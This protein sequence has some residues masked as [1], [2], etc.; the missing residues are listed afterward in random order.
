[1]ELPQLALRD[2]I[3]LGV[4]RALG[5]LTGLVWAPL[6][7]GVMYFVY[8]WRID[9]VAALRREYQ[10]LRKDGGPLVICANHLT[11]V[12]SLLVAWALGSPW[13]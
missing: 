8:G 9:D 7:I 10:T 1:V 6:V 5:R 3:A 11:M 12:D 4:Q 13:W 2:R